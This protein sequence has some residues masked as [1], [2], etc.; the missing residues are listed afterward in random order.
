MA[1]KRTPGPKRKIAILGTTPSRMQAPLEDD[2]WEIWTIG[3]GGKDA[4]DWDL[5]FEVHNTWPEDFKDYLRD[6]SKVKK[7]RMVVTLGDVQEL[8]E[9]W[10]NE[11]GKDEK[12]RRELRKHVSGKWSAAISMPKE[13]LFQKYAR[14]MW[15]SSSISYC[16]AMA[17]ERKPT[18][19]GLWGID[20]ESG[21]EYISQ[22]V[23]CAHFIDLARSHGISI[24]MPAGCGLERDIS[25]YPDRYE[26]H[27]ALTLEKKHQWLSGAI[28]QL[29]PQLEAARMDQYRQEGAILAMKSMQAPEEHIKKA[30][31]NL[32]QINARYASIGANMNHLKGELSATQFYRRMYVWGVVDPDS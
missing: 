1:K 9:R 13:L 7:P 26:T 29:E 4:H 20:L 21:E 11:H 10:V 5:L 19:I 23:G 3:P 12:H 32:Q 8:I 27:L 2:E 18:D 6:L 30:E 22:H 14:R 25:P 31:E 24:H 15:F 16:M 17:I 28:G